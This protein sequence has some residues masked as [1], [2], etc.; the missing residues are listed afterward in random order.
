MPWS[1]QVAAI[2]MALAFYLLG[3]T[4]ASARGVFSPSQTIPVYSIE[5]VSGGPGTVVHVKGEMFWGT[6]V[7]NISKH[8]MNEPIDPPGP[9]LTTVDS[10]N[11]NWTATI[12]IPSHWPQGE[13]I[14]R[15]PIF[16]TGPSGVNY[17]MFYFV[18]STLPA[19][20]WA[21]EPAIATTLGL[22]LLLIGALLYV[23]S[24]TTFQTH[25]VKD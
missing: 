9:P 4:Q 24:R 23:L 7:V 16:I 15:G 5:P 22:L 2:F 17:A 8:N 20:G 21:D 6:A 11:G 25:S 18:P 12:V 14:E 13:P 1:K 3:S 10:P 19:T